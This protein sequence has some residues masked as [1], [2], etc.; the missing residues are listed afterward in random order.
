[1]AER[2]WQRPSLMPMAPT[3]ATLLAVGQSRSINEQGN[4][5][6]KLQ[7]RSRGGR[8]WQ[9]PSLM[10][11]APTV[12]TLLAVGQ[13]RSINEQG[14]SSIADSAGGSLSSFRCMVEEKGAAKK[15]RFS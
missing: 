9:R 13:S 8:R 2:R 6:R 15:T 3:V 1:M 5:E 10:P 14:C 7:P 11:M 12:A 4:N